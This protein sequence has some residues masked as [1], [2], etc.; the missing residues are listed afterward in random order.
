MAHLNAV[1]AQSSNQTQS[2]IPDQVQVPPPPLSEGMKRCEEDDYNYY[3][4][5]GDDDLFVCWN[6]FFICLFIFYCFTIL[7]LHYSM[8]L[9]LHTL[10]L[11]FIDLTLFYPLHLG[12]HCC[13][14]IQHYCSHQKVGIFVQFIHNFFC[15]NHHLFDSV[16]K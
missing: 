9:L 6:L 5:Y 14:R 10:I 15:L 4:C 8:F 13:L 3:D 16:E 11:Q 2:Q 1:Q 7:L 12:L